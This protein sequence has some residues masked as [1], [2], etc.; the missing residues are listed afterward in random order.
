[1][2]QYRRPP[3]KTATN[4]AVVFLYL[5]LSLLIFCSLIKLLGG[6]GE[7]LNR[8]FFGVFGLSAYAL[9]LFFIIACVRKILNK[10]IVIDKSKA[11]RFIPLLLIGILAIHI[12]TTKDYIVSGY[13]NY[14][15]QCYTNGSMNAGGFV[16]GAMSYLLTGWAGANFALSIVVVAFFSVA[17]I[18]IY[19][20]FLNGGNFKTKS[21]KYSNKSRSRE[22]SN[23][24]LDE[25]T[26]IEVGSELFVGSPDGKTNN[27]RII[28]KSAF[29]S[30]KERDF[31]ILFPNKLDTDSEK[32]DTLIDKIK[33]KGS[34]DIL[35]SNPYDSK[36]NIEEKKPVPVIASRNNAPLIFPPVINIEEKPNI[37]NSPV[38]KPKPIVTNDKYANYTLS[39]KQAQIKKSLDEGVEIKTNNTKKRLG[40]FDDEKPVNEAVKP[41][42]IK[43]SE[44]TVRYEKAKQQL[45]GNENSNYKEP[46]NTFETLFNNNRPTELPRKTIFDKEEVKEEPKKSSY[47]ILYGNKVEPYTLPKQNLNKNLYNKEKEPEEPVIEDREEDEIKEVAIKEIVPVIKKKNEQDIFKVPSDLIRDLPD[48]IISSE[49]D[50]YDKI[51]RKRPE[52][53]VNSEQD[54]LEY[55]F[56]Q[57]TDSSIISNSDTSEAFSELPINAI[58]RGLRSDIG[59]SHNIMP[60]KKLN[61]RDIMDVKVDAKQV[62]IT[63]S[64]TAVVKRSRYIAPPEELMRMYPRVESDSI[65]EHQERC[66]ALRNVLL[67]YGIDTVVDR[68]TV[69]PSFTRYEITMP[70][71]VTVKRIQQI[72]DDI[73]MRLKANKLRIEAPIPGKN[74]VGVEIPN[75]HPSTVGL[76]EGIRS[77]AFKKEAEL[78]FLLGMNI[79]GE[80]YTCNIVKMPHLLIAGATGSGKSVCINALICSLLYKYSP[81]QVRL[82]LVDPK[83]VELSLYNGLPH[84][85]IPEILYDA[86]KAMNAMNWATKEMERRYEHFHNM[87]VRNLEEHNKK[88]E[89]EGMPVLP[90]IV[91]IIDELADLMTY[92]KRDIEE[93][94]KRLAQLARAAGIHLIFATQRPSVDIITGTIKANFPSRIAFAVSSFAD[95]KTILDHG[96]ADKLRGQGDM[97]YAPSGSPD[98]IRLQ[99]AYITNEEVEAITDFV[100]KNNVSYYDESIEAEINAVKS[101]KP[102]EASDSNDYGS[103]NGS[104]DEFFL[105]ALKLIIESNQASISMIQRRFSVG[106]ARAARLID[107]MEAKGYIGMA[108]GS[109]PR[110]VKFTMFEF[111]AIYGGD[112]A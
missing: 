28:K 51:N 1:M 40:I 92:K 14:L 95:S 39:Y 44:E 63:D 85:L 29:G 2:P 73:A 75:N 65:D 31:D 15:S 18:S 111:N 50:D 98:P 70:I 3:K 86:E 47:D 54:W 108:D 52:R 90:Y 12:I 76:R 105:P 30:S 81:D 4:S 69:G 13:G 26:N 41:V 17:F 24:Q 103:N 19:P 80:V 9:S 77:A 33:N 49:S 79:S 7:V 35:F 58:K 66:I 61:D 99:G 43:S 45:Y 97:L 87:R 94:I 64:P 56:V 23:N 106:Y 89:E 16:F 82:I 62:A 38:N 68:Y 11:I 101:M 5:I 8:I 6:V 48:G 112:S 20:L 74:A 27:N 88:A 72:S 102:D 67:E 55:D 22:Y 25:P 59:R 93:K 36:D 37:P 46:D 32:Q 21:V 109:K 78:L 60:S 53:K 42:N 34:Y 104:N 84:L 110:E 57:D 10:R 107:E 100:K 96:G 83:R 71:G 91:M